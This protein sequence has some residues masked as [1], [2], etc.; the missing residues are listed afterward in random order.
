MGTFDQN[1][2]LLLRMYSMM[3]WLPL[4]LHLGIRVMYVLPLLSSY[5]WTIIC[6]QMMVFLNCL[7]FVIYGQ[8]FVF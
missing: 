2:M 8:L 5:L 4:S 3:S 1:R 7:P 6:I